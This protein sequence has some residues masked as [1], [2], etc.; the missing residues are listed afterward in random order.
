[1]EMKPSCC[2]LFVLAVDMSRLAESP[3]D[4]KGKE[5]KSNEL[6][7]NA[8]SICSTGIEEAQSLSENLQNLKLEKDPQPIKIKKPRPK[9]QYKPEKW[10]L[11][12]QEQGSRNQLNL[13]IVGSLSAQGPQ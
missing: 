6:S 7:E 4:T 13:A 5:K 8:S 10:M 2:C 9:P 11:T 12:G 3:S 1:M